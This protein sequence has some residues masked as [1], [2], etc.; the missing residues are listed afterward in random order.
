MKNRTIF[1]TALCWFACVEFFSQPYTINRSG[2]APSG[3]NLILADIINS[4][5]Q[6]LSGDNMSYRGTQYINL[7][8]GFSASGLGNADQFHAYLQP[9]Q[10]AYISS[11]PATIFPNVYPPSI[12][13]QEKEN[14]YPASGISNVPQY[15]CFEIGV[16]LPA[17][18]Q[19]KIDY[20]LNT[21]L[22]AAPYSSYCQ[23]CV[24][25]GI[26]LPVGYSYVQGTNPYDRDQVQIE[27]D[28]TNSSGQTYT[29]YGFY[30]KDFAENTP[31]ATEPNPDFPL[32]LVPWTNNAVQYPYRVR[33]APPTTGNWTFVVK[34]YLGG[35][36]P[37]NI[38]ASFTG[39][40]F[41]VQSSSDP[42]FLSLDPSALANPKAAQRLKFA[43]TGNTFFGIGEDVP[44]T[45]ATP[46]Q[47]KVAYSYNDF[48]W[49]TPDPSDFNRQRADIDDVAVNNGNFVRIRLD[50]WS[51]AVETTEGMTGSGVPG[52]TPPEYAPI[53]YGDPPPKQPINCITNYDHNQRLMWEFDQTLALCEK[54]DMYIMLTLLDDQYFSEANL[55]LDISEY[56]VGNPPPYAPS[57][58][59][60]NPYSALLGQEPP[61]DMVSPVFASS[62]YKFFTDQGA[63]STY[64]KTLFYIIARWGYSPHI[65]MW[66]HINE[67]DQIG[68]YVHSDLSKYGTYYSDD[69]NFASAVRS[70]ITN[71]YTYI[72]KL[73]PNHLQ[74]TGYAGFNNNNTDITGTSNISCL[75]VYSDHLYNGFINA[76]SNDFQT[77]NC[78]GCCA[79]YVTASGLNTK[80]FVIGETGINCPSNNK[81]TGSTLDSDAPDNISDIEF[82]KNLWLT[83]FTGGLTTALHW[84]DW[85]QIASNTP[86]PLPANHRLNFKAL[87]NFLS[88]ANVDFSQILYPQSQSQ[89]GTAGHNVIGGTNDFE[90]NPLLK[91]IDNFFL[92]NAPPG[93]N[94]GTLAYGYC[95][96]RSYWWHTDP[97]ISTYAPTYKCYDTDIYHVNPDDAYLI[98]PSTPP[99]GYMDT[100][101]PSVNFINLQ[102]NTSFDL[103]YYET[104][105]GTPLATITATSKS[106]G[107]LNFNLPF[108]AGTYTYSSSNPNYD[109]PDYA[110]VLEL[111]CNGCHREANGNNG[112]NDGKVTAINNIRKT[113][114]IYPSPTSGSVNI[115]L[116]TLT[117]GTLHI[118]LKDINGRIMQ[119]NIFNTNAGNNT[120]SID[121]GSLDNGVYGITITDDTGNILKQDR[122][123]LTK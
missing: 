65:A 101:D 9:L 52:Y 95:N 84:S 83:T 46:M 20:F 114:T 110:Y 108:G 73:D 31:L 68:G 59:K 12:P 27:V 117:K 90:N 33:F 30:Y 112:N 111:A 39:A 92:V 49:V 118:D 82:R 15:R 11:I 35:T 38:A 56:S 106:D 14:A 5:E 119:S 36:A 115:N 123:I 1:F 45:G 21:D 57:I 41:N 55:S 63:I 24:P 116:N 22:T 70:W 43:T 78:G 62:I 32:D 50:P 47:G 66:E 122:I 16:Q 109:Y 100:N 86:P 7:T 53:Y 25:Q 97:I 71:N 44:F 60:Y 121:I 28:F 10:I 87:S 88:T 89:C 54:D 19:T 8:D 85:D 93:S 17:D 40:S 76:N 94:N 81:E 74:T 98:N 26:T 96:N 72:K 6:I 4:S 107:T 29:R 79:G 51:N 61:F 80:P 2:A 113:I 34:L 103:T 91:Y 13:S 58:Y 3:T 120:F 23:T 102:P 69:A 37:A 99:I 105:N 42:G 67:T 48:G 104:N 75:D 18:V 77:G 64:Q